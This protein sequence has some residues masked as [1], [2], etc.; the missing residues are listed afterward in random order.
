MGCSVLH[1]AWLLF[2]KRAFNKNIVH[3]LSDFEIHIRKKSTGIDERED[4]Y[5]VK[6]IKKPLLYKQRPLGTVASAIIC[7]VHNYDL[8]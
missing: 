5:E 6:T 2:I 1:S 4:S 8:D 7:L 3:N